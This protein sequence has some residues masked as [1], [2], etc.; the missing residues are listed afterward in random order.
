[1][2]AMVWWVADFHFAFIKSA[3]PFIEWFFFTHYNRVCGV[4]HRETQIFHLLR[5]VMLLSL[6]WPAVTIIIII[7]PRSTLTLFR[8]IETRELLTFHLKM[9]SPIESTLRQG[10]F[11]AMKV[12]TLY[13]Q[14][15]DRR[16]DDDADD[17][18]ACNKYSYL[19]A[20]QTMA[21]GRKYPHSAT[22]HTH[23]ARIIAQCVH[24]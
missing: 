14:T 23:I 21:S 4:R 22:D 10:S 1:M 6:I 2:I 11:S 15:P 17:G 8:H 16:Y 13:I 7:A 24:T 5:I 18:N 20:I 12:C 19:N 3:R 9:V